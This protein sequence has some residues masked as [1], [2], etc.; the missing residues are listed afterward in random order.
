MKTFT[1]FSL[2]IKCFP[3]WFKRL[4]L[5][6]KEM[7]QIAYEDY[8]SFF[9]YLRQHNIT[10][11]KDSFNALDIIPTQNEI[12]LDKIIKLTKEKSIQQLKDRR[13]IITK[14]AELLDGHHRVAA[15]NMMSK[16]DEE[17][18]DVYVVDCCI[19]ELISIAKQFPRSFVRD[20][21]E[22]KKCQKTTTTLEQLTKY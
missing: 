12:N 7:P 22:N 5:S 16:N 4:G 10:I 8:W 20:I 2:Y 11:R 21:S 3:Q 18:V 1:Q 15:I 14:N 6:R 9:K 13:F 17:I 19:E